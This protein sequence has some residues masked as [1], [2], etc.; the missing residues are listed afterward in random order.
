MPGLAKA[1]KI[2][3]G[4]GDHPTHIGGQPL[5][6]HIFRHGSPIADP[7]VK[8]RFRYINNAVAG[9]D[10]QLNIGVTFS[11]NRQDRGQQQRGRLNGNVEPNMSRRRVAKLVELFNRAIY[12]GHRLA[13]R[14]GQ[15]LA[16]RRQGYAFGRTVQQTHAQPRLKSL[17]RVA[18][19]RCAHP[20]F[21]GSFT[22]TLMAG[23]GE[24]IDKIGHV[25]TG[26]IHKVSLTR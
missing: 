12:G 17:D 26:Y 7:C 8:P 16:C 25:G 19:R 20:K 14:A 15:T 13:H 21:N 18:Q 2:F 22:K 24:K 23:D 11:K 4:C 5:R 1:G 6:H 10:I 9:H 3:R